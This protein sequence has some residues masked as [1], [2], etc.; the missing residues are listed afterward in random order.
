MHT[1]RLVTKPRDGYRAAAAF[2]GPPELRRSRSPANRRAGR[3]PLRP[4][5]ARGRIAP[6]GSRRDYS[7]VGGIRVFPRALRE[8]PLR[9]IYDPAAETIRCSRGA[10]GDGSS[11]AA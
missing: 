11:G 10:R 6:G 5:V 9:E 1:L 7:P 8:T 4:S 3:A 2:V